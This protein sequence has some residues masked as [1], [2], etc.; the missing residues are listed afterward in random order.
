VT[1]WKKRPDRMP[2]DVAVNYN[3]TLES[4]HHEFPNTDNILLCP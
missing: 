4:S 2:P 1:N 3:N